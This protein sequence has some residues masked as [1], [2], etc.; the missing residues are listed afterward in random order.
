MDEF[1]PVY[2]RHGHRSEDRQRQGNMGD[3]LLLPFGS[4]MRYNAR[5]TTHVTLLTLIG[6][7]QEQ[8]GMTTRT[9]L[10]TQGDALCMTS[11]QA[12]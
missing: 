11:R 9:R 10:E 3:P 5:G 7:D 1:N 4:T 2:V 8:E 6:H 12:R